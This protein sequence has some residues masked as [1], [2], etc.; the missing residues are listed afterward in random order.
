MPP[1]PFAVAG[2]DHDAAHGQSVSYERL[3]V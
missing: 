1:H 3:F 2:P